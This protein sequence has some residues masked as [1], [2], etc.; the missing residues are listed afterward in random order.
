MNK[1]GKLSIVT[2]GIC[3][4]LSFF[5]TENMAYPRLFLLAITILSVA[6]VVFAFLSKKVVSIIFGV[7]LNGLTLVGFFILVLVVG[8]GIN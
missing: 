3:I 7:L 6:G 5:I 4:A 8:I 1:Y 2:V